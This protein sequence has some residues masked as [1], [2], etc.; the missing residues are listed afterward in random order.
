MRSWWILILFD[1]QGGRPTAYTPYVHSPIS[2][3]PS[4]VKSLTYVLVTGL[5]ALFYPSTNRPG[6]PCSLH[7]P[8]NL[9]NPSGSYFNL[10][11]FEHHKV[12]VKRQQISGLRGCVDARF[13]SFAAS[14][15]TIS[16]LFLPPV[17]VNRLTANNHLPHYCYTI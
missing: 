7:T 15:W 8:L 3:I 11:K 4:P 10:N 6:T 16:L 13:I 9:F 14:S 17:P 5:P 1:R 2:A 12:C